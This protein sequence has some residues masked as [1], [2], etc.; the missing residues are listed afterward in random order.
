MVHYKSENLSANHP[1]TGTT[2][3]WPK[4]RSAYTTPANLGKVFLLTVYSRFVSFG[5]VFRRSWVRSI[6]SGFS[7]GGEWVLV[8][9]VIINWFNKYIGNQKDSVIKRR[10][11]RK[12]RTR[13][14]FFK[15]SKALE[16]TEKFDSISLHFKQPICDELLLG[17]DR[18]KICPRA[19]I[20]WWFD[21]CIC[22]GPM[23]NCETVKQQSM[24]LQRSCHWNPY[25]A[26]KVRYEYN[27]AKNKTN[28]AHA[29]EHG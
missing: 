5:L 1:F 25:A 8:Q 6:T 10:N 23:G 22:M 21:D 14:F 9:P 2:N 24:T 4:H 20:F 3:P 11:Y 7:L 12:E 15:K 27:V 26:H 16:L 18:Q 19:D 13:F 28:R 29:R 17:K